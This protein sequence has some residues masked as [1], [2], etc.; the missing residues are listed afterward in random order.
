MCGERGRRGDLQRHYDDKHPVK[1]KRKTE[2]EPIPEG[3]LPLFE[4]DTA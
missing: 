4:E 1:R 2:P 3:Q